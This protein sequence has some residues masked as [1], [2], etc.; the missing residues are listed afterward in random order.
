MHIHK[1]LHFLIHEEEKSRL[2]TIIN[3]A[4]A[5]TVHHLLGEA[6]LLDKLERV[7]LGVSLLVHD[8]NLQGVG[9][10]SSHSACYHTGKER[11]ELL[12][13]SDKT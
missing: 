11:C 8:Q 1:H 6:W 5:H 13:L 2:N 7:K 3:H 4:E 9:H 12:S 10:E